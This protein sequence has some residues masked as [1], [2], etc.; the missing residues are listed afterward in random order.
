M[1]ISL[2]LYDVSLTSYVQKQP[3]AAPST[4]SPLIRQIG[5]ASSIS[6][7]CKQPVLHLDLKSA[8]VFIER[9]RRRKGCRLWAGVRI[10]RKLAVIT[11][12]GLA[13][14][15]RAEIL[16]GQPH[17]E[18]ADTYSFGV[19][20]YELLAAKLPYETLIPSKS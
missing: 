1:S 14:V 3:F 7:Q 11:A 20:L 5:W 4:L 19:L 9:A 13:A 18:S 12:Y 6:I 16:R 2:S 17:D 8:N 15:D 10:R